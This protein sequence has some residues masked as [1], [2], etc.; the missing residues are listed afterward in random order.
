MRI[1]KS[2]NGLTL[3]E[4]LMGVVILGTAVAPVALLMTS[5]LQGAQVRE[6][7][8]RTLFLA[9]GRMEEVLALDYDEISVGQGLSDWATAPDSVYR[10]V[11]VI[12]NP[13]GSFDTD[14]KQ[15]TVTVGS[16][17]LATYKTNAQEP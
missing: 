3:I 1:W 2:D 5:G 13:G 4:V 10:A 9:Q 15:I 6:D 17:S 8:A 16:V 7:S 12:D 11:E 14:M